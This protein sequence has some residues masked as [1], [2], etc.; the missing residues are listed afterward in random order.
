M[1]KDSFRL[2]PKSLANTLEA[3]QDAV[4]FVLDH[5][6]GVGAIRYSGGLVTVLDR[7][8]IEDGACECYESVQKKFEQMIGPFSKKL[9]DDDRGIQTDGRVAPVRR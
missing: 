9:Q 7:Q 1:T 4:S 8:V 3:P 2:T 5:F 6:E